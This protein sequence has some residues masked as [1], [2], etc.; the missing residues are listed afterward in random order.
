MQHP[1]AAISIVLQPDEHRLSELRA[2][3]RELN[4]ECLRIVEEIDALA[5]ESVNSV[6]VLSET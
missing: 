3:L 2:R 6:C 5:G 4:E 1:D